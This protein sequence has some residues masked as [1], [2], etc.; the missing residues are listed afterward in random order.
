M[1][2]FTRALAQTGARV[3]GVSD[4]PID[5]IPAIARENLAHYLQVSFLGDQ[6]KS[7][8]EIL[9]WP[10]IENIEQ[11]ECLWEPCVLMAAAVREALDLPGMD[12]NQT[13]LFR[14]K[15]QMKQR[16]AAAGVRTPRYLK[17]SNAEEC[18]EAVNLIGFPLIIKPLSGAGSIDTHRVDNLHE[19]ER[20]LEKMRH[21]SEIAVEEFIDGEEYT[22]DTICIDGEIV[23]ESAGWYRPRPLVDRQHEWISGQTIVLRDLDAPHLAEG[24]EMGREVLRALG[25]R[26]G[27]THMEW[28]RKSDGEAVF[29][30]IG[31]RPPGAHMVDLMNYTADID[32]FAGWAEAVT[33]GQ[34]SQR[35]ERRY[36]SAIISKRARGQGR[37]HHVEG[38]DRLQSEFGEHIMKVNLL[39]VGTPRNDWRTS[40]L[41]DGF[42]ILRHP[43]L[44][45]L[46][47]MADRV[48]TD[49]QLYAE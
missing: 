39:P 17:A 27:F 13:I 9:S 8:R 29:G 25:F 21:V 2:F 12:I 36:N 40:I 7:V 23:Y 16:V 38:L 22:F 31:A 11:V 3:I 34:F 20:G 41:S 49:L 4:R 15:D 43:D 28:Y 1:P 37:I 46:L 18:L 5:E 6:E 24:R 44:P 32:L 14:Y 33:A 19:L 45:A 10:G 35:A 26:T 48:G 42:V 30:E 47:N